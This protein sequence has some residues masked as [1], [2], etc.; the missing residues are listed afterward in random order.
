MKNINKFLKL[1]SSALA[2]L[3]LVSSFALVGCADT[4]HDDHDHSDDGISDSA[5]AQMYPDVSLLSYAD[6]YPNVLAYNEK[7]VKKEL[8]S[9]G[10]LMLRVAKIDGD[11]YYCTAGK[12]QV[13]NFILINPPFE[14][15]AINDFLLLSVKSYQITSERFGFDY[16]EAYPTFYVVDGSEAASPQK[17]TAS[18]AYQIYSQIPSM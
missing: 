9:T 10:V 8:H 17:I 6:G 11:Q 18:A 4:G 5:V 3:L 7:D 16:G 13:V 1:I 15:V 12:S 2:I 14:D